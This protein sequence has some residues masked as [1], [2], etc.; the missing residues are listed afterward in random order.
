MLCSSWAPGHDLP[1]T[2]QGTVSSL[3]SG[4]L[5]A[6]GTAQPC[7]PHA[8]KMW[9]A[10][11]LVWISSWSLCESQAAPQHPRYPVL[12]ETDDSEKNSSAE[13]VTRAFTNTPA[14]M[15][16]AAPSPIALT[17]GTWAGSSTSP[18][19]PAGTTHRTDMGASV[20]A[21]GT[22]DRAASRALTLSSPVSAW[23]TPSP[24]TARSPPHTPAPDG[25]TWS[26]PVTPTMPMPPTPAT[27]AQTSAVTP[28][29]ASGPTD[30]HSPPTHT[31]S[32]STASPVTPSSQALNV[33]TRGP[34]IQTPLA[35]TVADT[36]SGP[37]PTLS[38][39]TS[40]PT[41]PSLASVPTTVGT[42]TKTSEP[43]ASTA[44]A[45]H[46]SLVPKVESPA[47][48]TRPGPPASTPGATGPGTTQAPEQPEP[49]PMPGTASTGPPPGSSGGSKAPATDPC[50]LSTQ[51]R[52]LV[53]SSEPLAL[54]SVNRSFLLAVLLLGVTLFVLVLAL[55][56]LQAYESYKKKDY[57]QVDYLINGMYADAEM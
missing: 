20:T 3:R 57:T 55:F 17:K 54:A 13:T 50:Q 14:R 6:S 48:T 56:A 28:A 5:G 46:T 31:P 9:A 2:Q 24:S 26:R 1:A 39:T 37:T 47:L 51:G 18:A 10:L 27:G 15:T 43:A 36:A 7:S 22:P 11:V 33:S 41:T 32:H 53:V 29:S 16:S 12:N 42:T 21:E 44:P 40:E 25:S 34:T 49:E 38:N 30:T 23:Q 35:Q 4:R 19:V 52:Y 8:H 45:S